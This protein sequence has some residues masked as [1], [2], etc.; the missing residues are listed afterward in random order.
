[1]LL[2]HVPLPDGR[3]VEVLVEGPPG[4]PVVLAFHGTPSTATFW[5]DWARPV[6][7]LGMTLVAVT[8]PG[9]TNSSR[10]PGRRAVDAGADSVA[11]LD[12]LGIGRVAALGYSGGCPHALALGALA[13]ERCSRVVAVAG[14][15]PY[16]VAGVD[17]LEGMGEENVEEFNA[18]LDGESSLRSW[19]SRFGMPMLQAGADEIAE[20]FGDLVDDSD[21]AVLAGGWAAELAAEFHRVHQGGPDGWIDDDLAFISPWGFEP[22]DVAVPVTLW[23]A[24]RDRMAPISHSRWLAHALPIADYREMAGMGHLALLRNHRADIVSSLLAPLP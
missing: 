5:S 15:V 24:E 10:H 2:K 12:A 6:N 4:R 1:M 23:H 11:V 18:A 3:T 19:I 9:Y 8:R 17:F 13:P 14:V 21:R 16:G 20:A 7:E 22:A